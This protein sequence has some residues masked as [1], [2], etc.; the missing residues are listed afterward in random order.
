MDGNKK[1][2]IIDFINKGKVEIDPT[3]LEYDQGKE[4]YEWALKPKSRENKNLRI[5][6]NI[7]AYSVGDITISPT[8]ETIGKTSIIL[9]HEFFDD[10]SLLELKLLTETKIIFLTVIT[11]NFDSFLGIL[12]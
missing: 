1:Q 10:D 8:V 12:K 7:S 2:L 3:K 5:V 4:F 9:D 6:C 11:E